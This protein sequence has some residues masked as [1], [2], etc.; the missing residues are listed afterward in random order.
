MRKYINRD[1]LL[2]TIL[3]I[4]IASLAL[5]SYVYGFKKGA[6]YSVRMAEQDTHVVKRLATPEFKGPL[7]YEGPNP[8]TLIGE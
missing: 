8:I 1:T 3:A 6:V 2:V 5:A 4:S 7:Y